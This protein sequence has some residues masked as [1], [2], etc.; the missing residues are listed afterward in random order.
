VAVMG[1]RVEDAGE[2]CVSLM[3][4]G[5]VGGWGV[6]GEKGEVRVKNMK[7]TEGTGAL[8]C[9]RRKMVVLQQEKI[10][11]DLERLDAPRKVW[12]RLMEVIR[13]YM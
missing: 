10:M 3:T 2:N 6:E 4:S 1:T 5:R 9:V 12:E 13:P 7:G 8:F 11:E